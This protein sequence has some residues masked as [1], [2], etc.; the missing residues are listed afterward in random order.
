MIRRVLTALVLLPSSLLAQTGQAEIGGYLD[1]VYEQSIPAAGNALY[2]HL[3]H[4]RLNTRWYATET[5]T[6]DLELRSRIFLGSLVRETP[7]FAERLKHDAG[8]GSFGIT[9]WNRGESVGYA[10]IDRCYMNWNPEHLQITLGRQRIAWGTNLV[11][12]PVDLFNPLSILDFDYVERPA[13]DAMRVQYYTGEVSKIEA[14]AKPGSAG[15][16]RILAAQWSTNQCGY[17]FHLLA[18]L[19]GDSWCAG[20]A[21]AGDI[22]GGGFRGEALVSEIPSGLR[23]AS[24]ARIMAS[25]ALSGD[26]TFP[27]SLYLHTEILYNSEGVRKD[28]AAARPRALLLGLLSP[29]RL[30]LYQ[31]LS[32]DISSLVRGSLFCIVN[33]EDRSLVGVPSLTWSVVTDLDVTLIAMLFRGGALT[34]FGQQ[35]TAVFGRCK[36]SF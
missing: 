4:G 35:G 7:A 24:G 26:Y 31:E 23:E 28:A 36:W 11:W 17:D 16:P 29:G 20:T 22:G 30:S 32:Y 14:A 33:P 3:L 10:E 34:E 15:S 21:W 8:L 27:N 6:G 12:N 1:Y 19:K 9:L 5:L 2:T 13:V 25:G 18:G